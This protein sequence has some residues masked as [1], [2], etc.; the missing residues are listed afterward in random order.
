MFLHLQPFMNILELTLLILNSNP[1]VQLQRGNGMYNE[2][3]VVTPLH[4]KILV[5]RCLKYIL[6]FIEQDRSVVSVCFCSHYFKSTLLCMNSSAVKSKGKS[7]W[8]SLSTLACQATSPHA[9]F[10]LLHFNTQT[11]TSYCD[12][13]YLPCILVDIYTCY[14][15]G[16][17]D[18]CL[19]SHSSPHTKVY[20]RHCTVGCV[21]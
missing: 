16:C 11:E 5:S 3:H 20:T 9:W 2:F 4:W 14:R 21:S 7:L 19:F 1:Y 15:S 10:I 12:S 17:C 6:L 13:G 18:T 8:R